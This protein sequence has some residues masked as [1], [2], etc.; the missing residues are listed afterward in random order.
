MA[1][2]LELVAIAGG[3]AVLPDDGMRDRLSGLAVPE[4][5]R[6]ALIG[7]ADRLDVAG[8]DVC[9]ADGLGD[10]LEGDQDD[11]LGVVLDP[12]GLGIVLREFGVGA[13]AHLTVMVEDEHRR[14]RGALVD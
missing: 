10:H 3:A 6:L 13:A 1:L 8:A 14:S 7:D 9:V 5:D 2:L 12:A 11:L 4:D